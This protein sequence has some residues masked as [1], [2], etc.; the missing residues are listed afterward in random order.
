M[1]IAWYNL[2]VVGYADAEERFEK[3]QVHWFLYCQ[4][5]YSFDP[6][7]Y[8]PPIFITQSATMIGLS[9]VGLVSSALTVV[10]LMS[11]D[12]ITSTSASAVAKSSRAIMVMNIGNMV[13]AVLI[14]I[15]GYY[16]M[17]LPFINVL[18]ACGLFVILSALNP[19][20]RVYFSSEIKDMVRTKLKKLRGN[21]VVPAGATTKTTSG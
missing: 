12:N 21:I 20:A 7:I 4:R 11:G 15:Y 8:H 19:L 5:A 9:G 1:F 13:A 17:A 6:V 10:T 16:N 3:G 2:L 14:V 18:G